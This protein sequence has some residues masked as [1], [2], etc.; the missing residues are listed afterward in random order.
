MLRF[1]RI[2]VLLCILSLVSHPGCTVL[3][4]RDLCPAL[5]VL[6]FPPLEAPAVLVLGTKAGFRTDLLSAGLTEYR[7]SVERGT[8]SA[9]VRS[10]ADLPFP[11]GE[12]LRI[13]EGAECPALLLYARTYEIRG[14]MFRDSVRMHK[15]YCTL[16]LQVRSVDGNLPYSFTVIGNWCG[17][18]PAGRV[19]PGPFRCRLLPDGTGCGTLRIPRQ[20]DDSLVLDLVGEDGIL[21]SFALGEYLRESGYDWRAEQLADAQILI[22]YARTYVS[23]V[24]GNWSKILPFDIVI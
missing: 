12:E 23:F 14:E 17:F 16:D 2:P 1:P 13:P 10:P 15:N 5:L 19:L 20:G 9:L 8:V 4:D 22:D 6:D 3:E 11:A 24:I 18:D 21:R 7:T